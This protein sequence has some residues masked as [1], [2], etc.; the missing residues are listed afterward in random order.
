MADEKKKGPSTMLV[1][2]LMCLCCLCVIG[3][4]QYMNLPV[5]A[6]FLATQ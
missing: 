3:T 2:F 6:I 1:V 5:L 4:M